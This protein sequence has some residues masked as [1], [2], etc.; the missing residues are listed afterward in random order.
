MR[1]A[2]ERPAPLSS[3][4]YVPA[5]VAQG[6]EQWFPKPR[7]ACSSHAGG[8][9]ASKRK[10]P[11][12]PCE[13]RDYRGASL[14]ST[15]CTEMHE[16]ALED[17]MDVTQN[18]RRTASATGIARGGSNRQALILKIFFT[19]IPK[20]PF[21]IGVIVTLQVP[22]VL[23]LMLHVVLPLLILQEPLVVAIRSVLAAFVN[24]AVIR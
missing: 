2:V 12:K 17:Y 10:T 14:R 15:R 1:R 13:Y 9:A 21:F 20:E 16:D 24:V 22:L 19:G 23:S 6:I 7:V 5:P 3:P 8:I 4:Q 18:R 11:R